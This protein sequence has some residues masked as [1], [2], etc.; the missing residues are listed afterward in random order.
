MKL[1]ILKMHVYI[2]VYYWKKE[3][4]GQLYFNIEILPKTQLLFSYLLNKCPTP[5][6][7]HRPIYL[8]HGINIT[9]VILC[10]ALFIS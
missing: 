6:Q 10:S 3:I 8:Q 2:Y 5:V 1:M 7:N 4:I 9:Q